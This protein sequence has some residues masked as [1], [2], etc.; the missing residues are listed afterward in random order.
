LSA[1]VSL[2]HFS[3]TF[4]ERAKKPHGGLVVAADNCSNGVL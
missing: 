4:G 3:A 1:R 2:N